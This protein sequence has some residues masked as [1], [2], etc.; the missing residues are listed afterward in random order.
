MVVPAGAAPGHVGFMTTPDTL[1]GLKR[2]EAPGWRNE[3][4]ARLAFTIGLYRPGLKAGRLPCPI[5]IAIGDHDVVVVNP[6]TEAA[7][8]RAGERATVKHYLVGHFESYLGEW[9]ERAVSD[10]V[11]FLHG[12]ETHCDLAAVPRCRGW[13][14]VQK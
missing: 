4:C 2:L 11:A 1:P 14:R 8:R 7:A 13:G 10:Q 9:F 5:L 12:R 3:M 6:T